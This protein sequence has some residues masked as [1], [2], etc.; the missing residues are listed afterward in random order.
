MNAATLL[1]YFV[2]KKVINISKKEIIMISKLIGSDVILGQ[3]FVNSVLSSNN[4]I[5]Y[6]KNTAKIHTLIMKPNFGCS[7]KEIYS[8]VIK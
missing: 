3:R 4:K 1:K 7:T 5:K 2:K 6:F 8:K